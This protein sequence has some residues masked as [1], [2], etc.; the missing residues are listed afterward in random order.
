MHVGKKSDQHGLLATGNTERRAVGKVMFASWSWARLGCGADC[1]E[2]NRDLSHPA[3][4]PSGN[5]E[6]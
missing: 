6:I 1:H 4:D 2:A 3:F 5:V